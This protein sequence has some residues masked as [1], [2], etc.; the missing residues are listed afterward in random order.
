MRTDGR[1]GHTVFLGYVFWIFGFI[2]L[3]RFYYGKPVTGA[4]WALTLGLLLIGWIVDLFL[5]PDMNEEANHR[6]AEG[7]TDFNLAWVLLILLGTLGIHR[8]YQG[9]FLTGFIFLFT[10]GICGLG[11]LY[12]LFTLNT[13]ITEA[14]LQARSRA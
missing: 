5:V 12:D 13:Q 8:F 14:N 9:K 11:V 10:L 3:H 1:S 7:P 6:F 2:G 4:I